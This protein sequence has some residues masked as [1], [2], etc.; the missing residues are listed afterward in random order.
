MKILVTGSSGFVGTHLCNLLEEEHEIVKFDLKEGKDIRKIEMLNV[1]MR[2]VDSVIHLAALVVGPE[3]WEKPR[4]YF[5]TNGMGT[6]N[7]VLSAIENQVK[8]IIVTSSAAIYGGPLNPYGAS[9]KWAESVAETYKNRIETFVVRPFNIYGKGQNPAYGYA[10]HSFANGIKKDGKI[11]IFG[12]G[13]QTRDFISV[14]DITESMKYMLSSKIVPDEPVDLG[15]GREITINDLAN[16][17]AKILGKDTQINYTEKREE[18]YKS[19]ADTEGLKNIGIDAS[20][21]VGLEEGL[22][23]LILQ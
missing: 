17:E 15:T 2:G 9:K 22:R 1:S 11:T 6:L 8:R 21:F 12:D 10:I 23:D 18:P 4:A 16:L 5:E 19:L 20:K 13:N 7:V 14:K 3:S